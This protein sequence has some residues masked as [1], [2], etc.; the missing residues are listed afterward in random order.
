L[1]QRHERL[2][3]VGKDS[4]ERALKVRSNW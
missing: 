1:E 3:W 2:G 4:L